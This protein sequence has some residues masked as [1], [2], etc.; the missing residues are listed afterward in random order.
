M[1]RDVLPDDP[2][3]MGRGNPDERDIAAEIV[4]REREIER[5]RAGRSSSAPERPK[6]TSR[7]PILFV[8]GRAVLYDRDRGYRLTETQI[9]TIAELGRFRVVAAYDLRQHA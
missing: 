2:R 6:E 1:S 5:A 3:E 4:E 7:P 8:N 9:R